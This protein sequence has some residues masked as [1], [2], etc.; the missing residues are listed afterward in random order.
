VLF[1]QKPLQERKTSVIKAFCTVAA[2]VMLA[3]VPALAADA[4]SPD[5]LRAWHKRELRVAGIMH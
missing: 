2:F 4:P 3:H 1:R 5:T